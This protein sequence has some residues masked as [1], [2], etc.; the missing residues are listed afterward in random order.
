MPLAALAGP[1]QQQCAVARSPGGAAGYFSEQLA[2]YPQDQLRTYT[3]SC[4][5]STLA[6]GTFHMCGHLGQLLQFFHLIIFLHGRLG[7]RQGQFLS[8]ESGY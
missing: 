6:E 7:A 8:T 5:R 1:T 2:A 4:L 3:L